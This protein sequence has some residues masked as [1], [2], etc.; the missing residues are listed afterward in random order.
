MGMVTGKSVFGCLRELCEEGLLQAGESLEQTL[1]GAS[2]TGV[3]ESR[4]VQPSGAACPEQPSQHLKGSFKD[5][6]GEGKAR[7]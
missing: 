5:P 3:S 4:V 1:E 7:D 6:M 2:L